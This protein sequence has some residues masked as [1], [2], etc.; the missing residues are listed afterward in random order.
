MRRIVN[1]ET[2]SPL[3]DLLNPDHRHRCDQACYACLFRF[4]NQPYHGLLDWRLGLDV[5]CLLLHPHFNAGFDG[6]FTSAGLRDWPEL[7]DRY[8]GEVSTLLGGARRQAAG[9]LQLVQ[10]T[11]QTWMAVVHPFW[12][13]NRLLMSRSDLRDF[14]E[15]RGRIV[16]AT[17]FDLA[18][19]LVF[20]VERCRSTLL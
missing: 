7:A 18:R 3:V 16:P 14:F 11:P 1:R 13:W 4:G 19:R 12:D 6:D 15:Q 2:E 9:D 20:T 17:T 5:L 10:V 8:A